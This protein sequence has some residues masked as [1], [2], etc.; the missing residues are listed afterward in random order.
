MVVKM[1]E[2][3]S[4]ISRE[5]LVAWK[6]GSV[7]AFEEIVRSS[8]KRAY[9]VALGIVGNAEDARDISQE[10]F[11]AAHKARKSFDVDRPFFAWFYRILRNRCLNFLKSRARRREISLDVLVERQ[12]A[13]PRPDDVVIRKERIDSVWKALFTLSPEHREIIVLRSFQ[14][15]SYREIA[16]YLGISDGTVMSRLYYARKALAE[17]LKE[18]GTDSLQEEVNRNGLQADGE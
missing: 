2:Q 12:D 11:M 7:K 1:H 14:E 10:C 8:M 9:S 13:S 16:Q 6:R 4:E 15:L 17:A 18:T 3:V 5:T